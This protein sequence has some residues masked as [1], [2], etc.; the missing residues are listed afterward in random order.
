MSTSTSRG[1]EPTSVER[2]S[3]AAAKFEVAH[4]VTLSR[5]SMTTAAV[6]VTD[7][8]KNVVSDGGLQ[9]V[10]HGQRALVLQK[11]KTTQPVAARYSS[12]S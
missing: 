3:A 8:H 11:R 7:G 6:A 9:E 10:A 4:R 2:G 12:V 5:A 1:L